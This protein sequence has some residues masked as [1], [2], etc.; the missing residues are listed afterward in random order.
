MMTFITLVVV[1]SVPFWMDVSQHV[2]DPDANPAC[3][4]DDHRFPLGE[5]FGSGFDV[6][7]HVSHN[8]SQ[9]LFCSKAASKPGP[10][11]FCPFRDRMFFPLCGFLEGEVN[12][13]CILSGNQWTDLFVVEDVDRAFVLEWTA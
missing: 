11:P 13:F 12:G 1:L 10:P 6:W 7:H 5:G 8:L 2:M 9:T 4:A 3:C